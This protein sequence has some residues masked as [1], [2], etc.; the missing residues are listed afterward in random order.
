MNEALRLFAPLPLS[1]R[2]TRDAGVALPRS[3]ARYNAPPMYVPPKTPVLFAFYLM[4]RS[5]ALWGAD[6]EEFKPER[7]FDQ[8]LQ[9][10]LA[11]NPAIFTPFASGPRSVSDSAPSHCTR[12]GMDTDVSYQCLGQNYALNEVTLFLARLLQRFD[13][14]EIDERKQLPPPWKKG[15]DVD[16]GLKDPCSG[17]SRKDVEKIWP[18]FTIVIHINGGL[19]MR[20]KKASE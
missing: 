18:G 12:P 3:D 6:A 19:W 11:A 1:I 4:G 10:K 2:D 15:P 9:Q 8:E 7:W 20:F 5:K 13:E 14:F 17:T 16:I